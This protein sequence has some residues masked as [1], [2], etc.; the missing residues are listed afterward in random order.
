MQMQQ[1]RKY[2]RLAVDSKEA[3]KWSKNLRDTNICA[4]TFGGAFL[5][6]AL[7]LSI[8]VIG[9]FNMNVN[10]YQSVWEKVINQPR[11]MWTIAE[12][13]DIYK[14]WLSLNNNFNGAN[15]YLMTWVSVGGVYAGSLAILIT[16]IINVVYSSILTNYAATPRNRSSLKSIT[17]MSSLQIIICFIVFI[18]YGIC[19]AYTFTSKEIQTQ[20]VGV[21]MAAAAGLL[22]ILQVPQTCCGYWQFKETHN[23]EAIKEEK[24]R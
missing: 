3:F 24:F 12:Y 2:Y 18:V 10:Q 23:L 6:I 20:Y 15:Y 5:L 8:V 17:W 9:S 7:V 21:F 13:N 22:G 1:R 11:S 19:L 4:A 16:A 14:Q